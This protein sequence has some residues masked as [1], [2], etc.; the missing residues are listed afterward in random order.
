LDNRQAH[1]RAGDRGAD[2]DRRRIEWAGD[3]HPEVAALL[4][5]LDRADGGDDAGEHSG[6]L[7][8]AR[9]VDFERIAAK[10]AAVGEPPAL[11]CAVRPGLAEGGDAFA[12]FRRRAIE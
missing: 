12:E 5:A 1:A 11:R 10:P 8:F 2:R 7:G 9:G 4:D 3:A 6:S